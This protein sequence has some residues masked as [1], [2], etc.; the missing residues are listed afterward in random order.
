M[1]FLPQELGTRFMADLAL[2]EMSTFQT[3]LVVPHFAWG[4]ALELLTFYC[5]LRAVGQQLDAAGQTATGGQ[6]GTAGGDV[7]TVLD[8]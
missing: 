7:S 4:V 3:L 5:F 8:L 1:A 2:V 6:A